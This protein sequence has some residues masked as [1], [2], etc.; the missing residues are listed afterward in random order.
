[1]KHIV[2]DTGTCRLGAVMVQ[3]QGDSWRVIA[4]ASRNLR[5]V[6]RRYSQMEKEVLAIVWVYE[7]FN[8]YVVGREFEHETDHKPLG[9]TS[10]PSARIERWVL[11]LQGYDY[12]LVY[13]SGKANI[14]DALSR[15][16]Q[17]TPCDESGDK[18]DFVKMVAAESIS[19]AL[20]AK[21][22]ELESEQDP[23]LISVR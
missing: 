6:E 8:L 14:A 22:V 21:Q 9:K 1:M 10:K 23:E 12:K 3:L 16:N 20:S 15:H 19:S 13:L 18:I 17:T 4:Y 5:D 11:R 7:R 2:A